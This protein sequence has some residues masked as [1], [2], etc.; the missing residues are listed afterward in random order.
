[1]SDFQAAK[2]PINGNSTVA[3][4][5][6][7]ELVCADTDRND[8]GKLSSLQGNFLSLGFQF[9]L[10]KDHKLYVTA[11]LSGLLSPGTEKGRGIRQKAFLNILFHVYLLTKISKRLHPC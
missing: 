6:L 5:S 8:K 7:T 10:C 1:M 3:A 11:Y 4:F 2:G 9:F